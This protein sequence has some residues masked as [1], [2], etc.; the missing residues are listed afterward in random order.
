[1]VYTGDTG[2]AAVKLNKTVNIVGG[3]TDATKLSTDNNIGIVAAQDG[4]NGKLTVRLAKDI[5]RLE[6]RRSRRCCHR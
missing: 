3:E 2:S 6:Y 4:D 5:N 1:M